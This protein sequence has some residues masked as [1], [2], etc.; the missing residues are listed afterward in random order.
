MDSPRTASPTRPTAQPGPPTAKASGK[1]TRSAGM[2]IG[3]YQIGEE[4][5]SNLF[6]HPDIR[7]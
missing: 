3:D 4:G 2:Q 6:G 1:K 5:F 7:Y